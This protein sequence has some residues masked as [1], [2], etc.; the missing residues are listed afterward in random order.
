LPNGFDQQAL[1][2]IARY[3]RRPAFAALE[4]GRPGINAEVAQ[5]IVGVALVAPLAENGT[6]LLDVK[7]LTI[8][9]SIVV[10]GEQAGTPTG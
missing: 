2:G 6:N 7:P 1:L 4:E 8:G 10:G 3:N 5:R 9:R